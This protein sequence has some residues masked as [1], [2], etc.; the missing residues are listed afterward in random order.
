MFLGLEEKQF[1]AIRAY[2]AP[3][4]DEH[5]FSQT[6][7]NDLF[8]EATSQSPERDQNLY[9]TNFVQMSESKEETLELLTPVQI[10]KWSQEFQKIETLQWEN[11][12]EAA[13]LLLEIDPTKV[14]LE[15]LN[16]LDDMLF[17]LEY[18]LT[19]IKTAE[20]RDLFWGVSQRSQQLGHALELTSQVTQRLNSVE[21]INILNLADLG[22]DIEFFN[23]GQ[24]S[25]GDV[26]ESDVKINRHPIEQ[27]FEDEKFK[28]PQFVV[29]FTGIS[30]G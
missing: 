2:D 7:I 23:T 10:S 4:W 6:S 24:N 13:R 28:P 21:P 27:H 25:S 19:S 20:A 29:P 22:L 17:T 14:P 12:L 9:R 1:N 3:G 15:Y 8:D 30:Y 5:R 26:P 16:Q 11:P 18:Q